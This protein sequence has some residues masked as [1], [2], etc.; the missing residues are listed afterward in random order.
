MEVC[1]MPKVGNW[2][3]LYIRRK[4]KLDVSVSY[5]MKQL[6]KSLKQDKLHLSIRH[7]QL[8]KT[9]DITEF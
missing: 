6:I 5:R 8:L 2:L 7:S 1:I 3:I 4:E 9:N